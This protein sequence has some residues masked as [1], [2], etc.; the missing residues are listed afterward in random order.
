MG[1]VLP[2]KGKERRTST[3]CDSWEVLTGTTGEVREEDGM[4]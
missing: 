2:K 3:N 1:D 4:G